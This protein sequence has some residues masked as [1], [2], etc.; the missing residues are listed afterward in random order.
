MARG[1]VSEV[2]AESLGAIR[3]I[4][5]GMAFSIFKKYYSLLLLLALWEIISRLGLVN[6]Y[7]LPSVVSI[8]A[9]IVNLSI[10]GDLGYDT[11][12]TVYRAVFA[13]SMAICIGV[14]I[15][16]TMGKVKPVKWF[17]DPI[18]SVGFPTPK[19]TFLPIFILWFGLFDRPKILLATLAS[20][21]PI[22]TAT[23]L[24]TMGVDKYLIWSARNMGTSKRALLAKIILP[25]TLP[26][27]LNGMQIGLPI[28]IIVTIVSEMLMGG[29][30]LGNFIMLSQRFA[31]SPA[32]FAG[33]FAISIVGY[34]EMKGL[35]W[36]RAY[37][38]RWHEEAGRG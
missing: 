10:K 34:A 37:I 29:G 23:Y 21:F 5:S 4:D 17:F 33:L 24:G 11:L 31:D 13:F 38:L 27:I 1:I 30:G 19:I 18:L 6:A 16:I 12:L 8:V 35:E 32:V 25:A 36:L 2:E 15:G 3:K 22:A 9:R 7:L 20:S 26:Q 14:S 28:S